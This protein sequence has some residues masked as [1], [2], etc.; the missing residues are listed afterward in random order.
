MTDGFTLELGRVPVI[1]SCPHDGTEIPAEIAARMTDQAL[2]RPD[3]DWHVSRLY[4]FVGELG[5]SRIVPRWSRYVVDLNRDPSGTDLYPGADNTGIVPVT[6]FD[7]AEL[8]RVG[9]TPSSD[10]TRERI[11]SFFEPYHSAL[12]NE[13]GRLIAEHGV[14]VVFDAHSIRSEVPRFF[15]GVLSDLNLGSAAGAS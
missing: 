14:A 3:T 6:S 1:L 4:S 2:R 15:D 5:A 7:R 11:A 9:Q 12:E 13:I 8:Y 10:E